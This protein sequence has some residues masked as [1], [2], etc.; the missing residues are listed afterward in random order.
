MEIIH[1]TDLKKN[2][3]WEYI[4]IPDE[5]RMCM[6]NNNKYYWSPKRECYLLVP[7]KKKNKTTY[8]EKIIKI[9]KNYKEIISYNDLII[10]IHNEWNEHNIF[11][12]EYLINALI[13]G[14]TNN[15]LK[16]LKV[17]NEKNK[18]KGHNYIFI[19]I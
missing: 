4:S 1:P 18:Y 8:L 16:Q 2:M 15:N 3:T 7:K 17:E 14:I 13:K 5:P 9:L 6:I 11:K 10:Q 12:E 19:S